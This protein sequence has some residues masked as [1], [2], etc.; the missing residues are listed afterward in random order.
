[1]AC[2]LRFVLIVEILT[3]SNCEERIGEFVARGYKDAK[4]PLPVS[5]NST[6]TKFP[7]H[8]VSNVLTFS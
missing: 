1:M 3:N 7:Y 5:Y 8:F 2:Y 6:K 4:L